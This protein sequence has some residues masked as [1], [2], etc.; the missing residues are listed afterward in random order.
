MYQRGLTGRFYLED[1]TTGK[2][3]SLGTSDRIEAARLLHARNEAAYQPALNAQMARAYLVAGD[4][5]VSQRTWQFVM[6]ELKCAKAT[7]AERTTERYESAFDE[8]PF[9][10]LRHCKRRLKSAAGG[11]RKVRHLPGPRELVSLVFVKPMSFVAR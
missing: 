11:A 3:E 2:Q 6:D 7:S 5:Q 10:A 1:N 9:D 4:A 8:A